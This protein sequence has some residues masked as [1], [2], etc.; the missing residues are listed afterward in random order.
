MSNLFNT[1]NEFSRMIKTEY[2][3]KLSKYDITYSQY[4]LLENLYKKGDLS[5][6]ELL[7]IIGIKGSTLTGIIDILLMKGFVRR[8]VNTEDKRLRNIVITDKGLDNYKKTRKVVL[9]IEKR[10]LKK[11][12]KDEEVH[13]LS[14]IRSMIKNI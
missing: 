3:N 6:K 12:K 10:V 9:I 7:N 2:N 1:I 8:V 13:L 4:L 5:Q 11:I 14:V